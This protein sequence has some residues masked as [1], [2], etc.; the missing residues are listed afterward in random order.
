MPN[1]KLNET[2]LMV[3]KHFQMASNVDV[4][5]LFIPGTRILLHAGSCGKHL[6]VSCSLKA[7]L[8]VSGFRYGNLQ[9]H[10]SAGSCSLSWLSPMK[11]WSLCIMYHGH[12]M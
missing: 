7:E 9:R 1:N 12:P 4:Y 6:Q 10:T 8:I 3:V 11:S 2:N 5:V